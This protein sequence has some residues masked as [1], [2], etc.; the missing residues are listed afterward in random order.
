MKSNGWA[1]A[2]LWLTI[3]TFSPWAL[4]VTPQVSAGA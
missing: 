3:Q 2:L 4:A 1:I